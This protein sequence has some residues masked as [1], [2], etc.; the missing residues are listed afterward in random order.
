MQHSEQ[1]FLELGRARQAIESMRQA[2]SLEDLEEHWK[3]YLRRL[4]R[5][6]NKSVSHYGKSPRWNGW[7]GK[8]LKLRKG[9]PLLSYFINARGA[10]E[11][12]VGEIT[13]RDQGSVSV[14]VG[15]SGTA[16]IE[17]MEIR[18]GV[19]T[20]LRGTGLVLAFQPARVKL[21]PI[22]NRG[23]T[24][25]VPTQHLSQPID[26]DNLLDIADKGLAFYANFLGEAEAF[27]IRPVPAKP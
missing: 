4:E 25:L 9:D 3:D 13:Q 7:Q 8:F 19:I 16:F 22:T 20:E 6:W 26:P 23:V 21:L 12:T 5:V 1:P 2:G 27:F 14:N 15:P 18:N 24:H 10:D 11:H 17:R